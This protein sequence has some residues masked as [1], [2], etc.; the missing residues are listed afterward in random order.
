M[1]GRFQHLV[2]R[3]H[4][5]LGLKLKFELLVIDF[6]IP[7]GQHQNPPVFELEGQGLGNK[8]WFHP[9]SSGGHFYGFRTLVHLPNLVR[10]PVFLKVGSHLFNAHLMPPR[11]RTLP[12]PSVHCHL[13][14]SIQIRFSF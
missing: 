8:S 12:G 6:G 1:P 3:H 7:L 10:K 13:S 9:Q 4:P 2:R 5:G 14:A 11:F